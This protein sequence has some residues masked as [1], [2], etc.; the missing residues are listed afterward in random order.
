MTLSSE[1][2]SWTEV[3]VSSIISSA[4]E[5]D[6]EEEGVCANTA[7]DAC[8][9]EEEDSTPED[10]VSS[11]RVNKANIEDVDDCEIGMIFTIL[12]HI[13]DYFKSFAFFGSK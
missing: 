9:G 8:N 6:E 3:V 2:E 13:R 10:T 12:S 1:D 11:K 4:N 7:V 5:E